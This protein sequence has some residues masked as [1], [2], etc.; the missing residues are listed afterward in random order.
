MSVRSVCRE[1]GMNTRYFYESFADIDDLLGA[2]YD[3]V[4][5]ELV[6]VVGAAIEQAEDSLRATHAGGYRRRARLQFGRRPPRP[7]AVHRGARQSRADRPPRGGAGPAARRR[8]DRGWP[9]ARRSPI[10]SPRAVGAAIFTGAMAELAQQWLA[11]NLG[12][13][14]DA[15]VDHAIALIL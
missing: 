1:C 12:D 4:S 13:D 11:G 15:V 8:A 7:G 2:V 5:A 6:E 14:L 3:R 9:A 10:P